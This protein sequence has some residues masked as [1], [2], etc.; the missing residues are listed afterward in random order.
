MAQRDRAQPRPSC[1][2]QRACGDLWRVWLEKML[3]CA[4]ALVCTP[5]GLTPPHLTWFWA[6]GPEGPSP[7]LLPW[8]LRTYPME[9]TRPGAIPLL[10]TGWTLCPAPRR[11]GL[12]A[13]G[14]PDPQTPSSQTPALSRASKSPSG[15]LAHTWGL[16]T[17]ADRSEVHLPPPRTRPPPA[18]HSKGRRAPS[19]GGP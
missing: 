18:A 5:P 17:S 3:T 14:P 10:E 8:P 2:R 13:S 19:G 9:A 1:Q 12:Q 11:P 16:C 15:P 4:E 7:P 6:V